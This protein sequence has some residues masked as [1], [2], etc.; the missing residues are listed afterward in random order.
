M[1]GDDLTKE[2]LVFG[3]KTGDTRLKLIP[4]PSVHLVLLL[5]LAKT[6]DSLT[7]ERLV[8]CQLPAERHDVLMR[9]VRHR[10]I[11]VDSVELAQN[12]AQLLVLLCEGTLLQTT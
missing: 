7:D 4:P 2:F 3:L 9:E 11:A 1:E 12:L 8:V 10:F 5:T 6:I